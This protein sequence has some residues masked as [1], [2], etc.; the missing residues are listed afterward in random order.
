MEHWKNLSSQKYDR[1]AKKNWSS[2]S[3]VGEKSIKRNKQIKPKIWKRYIKIRAKMDWLGSFKIIPKWQRVN[4][5]YNTRRN[6]FC[7]HTE[8]INENEKEMYLKV[9]K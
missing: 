5:V 7:V 9:E 2:V 3:K 4:K 8:R 6:Y 1:E